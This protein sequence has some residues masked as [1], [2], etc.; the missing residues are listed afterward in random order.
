MN[1]IKQR[2]QMSR[3]RMWPCFEWKC[4][5]IILPILI[6]KCVTDYKTQSRTKLQ[7]SNTIYVQLFQV[8]QLRLNLSTLVNDF[9]WIWTE[10][11]RFQRKRILNRLFNNE[12]LQVQILINVDSSQKSQFRGLVVE[13]LDFD[14]IESEFELQSWYYAHIQTNILEKGRKLLYPQIWVKHMG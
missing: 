3:L 8:K 2:F 10:I 1:Q 7:K 13:V 11:M 12:Q 5:Q 14:M 4:V 9:S 6:A